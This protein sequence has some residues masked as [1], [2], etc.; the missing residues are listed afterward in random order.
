VVGPVAEVADALPDIVLLLHS[1]VV[2]VQPHFVG[3]V[4]PLTMYKVTGLDE[5]QNYSYLKEL[6]VILKQGKYSS[7]AFY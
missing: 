7:P 6:I 2:S 4:L 1:I 5:K 3:F